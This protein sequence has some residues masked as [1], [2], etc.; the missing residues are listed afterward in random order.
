MTRKQKI[1]QMIEKLPDD[2]TYARVVYHLGVMRSIEIGLEQAA[3]GE[4]LEHDEFFAQLEAEDEEAK[5]HL[6]AS[7]DGG[8]PRHSRAHRKGR[9]ADSG[10]VRKAR[11]KT[12][13]KT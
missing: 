6:D 5:N 10:N 13:R 9:A 4:G 7:G 11:E 12:R 1:L 3:R 8:S 2:V